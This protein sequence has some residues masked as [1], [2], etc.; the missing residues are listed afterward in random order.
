[1]SDSRQLWLCVEVRP[2][3]TVMVMGDSGIGG[4]VDPYLPKNC[5]F[6][7]WNNHGPKCGWYALTKKRAAT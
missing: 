4:F 6:G 2:D 5:W 3:G 7:G 1:M